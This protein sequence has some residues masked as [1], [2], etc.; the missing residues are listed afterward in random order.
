MK[1]MPMKLVGILKKKGI[2]SLEAKGGLYMKLDM[3]VM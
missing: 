3:L 2:I 1:K